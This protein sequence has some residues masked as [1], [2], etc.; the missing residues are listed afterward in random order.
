MTKDQAP[1]TN[2]DLSSQ[3]RIGH[4][5]LVIGIFPPHSPQAC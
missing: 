4:W 1:V 2:E 5:D 3:D